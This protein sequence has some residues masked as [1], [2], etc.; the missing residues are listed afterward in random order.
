MRSGGLPNRCGLRNSQPIISRV[1][2]PNPAVTPPSALLR[3][4]GLMPEQRSAVLR[5]LLINID[6]H[7]LDGGRGPPSATSL[8]STN[9]TF[10]RKR[11]QRVGESLLI[12]HC[13]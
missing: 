12:R 9:T 10:L 5:K 13:C 4:K 3:A 8:D 11:T 7:R 6:V 2:D 1:A